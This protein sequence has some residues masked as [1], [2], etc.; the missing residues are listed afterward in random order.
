[1]YLLFTLQIVIIA[2]TPIREVCR[3]WQT[4]FGQNYKFI[5]IPV[6]YMNAVY[7]KFY[8]MKTYMGWSFEEIYMLPIPLRNWF[9]DKW[10]EDNNKKEE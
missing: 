4:F 1:M 7:E 3:S 8:Y 9:F 5:E 2:D 6:E 10:I